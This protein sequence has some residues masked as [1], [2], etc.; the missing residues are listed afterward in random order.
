MLSNA[1][2]KK[3]KS[4]LRLANQEYKHLR[5]AYAI[6]LYKTYLLK[7]SKDTTALKQLASSYHKLNQYDSALKYWEKAV[8]LGTIKTAVLAELYANTSQYGQAKDLYKHIVNEN[9]TKVAEARLY[10]FTNINKLLADSLDYTLYNTKLNSGYNDFNGVL[11]KEGMVFESNRV[12]KKNKPKGL[13]KRLFTRT[14]QPSEFAWDG[15]GYSKLYFY[16]NLDSIRTSTIVNSNWKEKASQKNYIDYSVQTPND[17]KKIPGTYNTTIPSFDPNGVVNFDAFISDKMNVGAVSFTADGKRAYYTRNQ[18]RSNGIYQLEIWES[19]QFNGKWAVNNRMFFNNPSFS[20]FHPVITPDGK[21]LYYVSDD[22]TGYGGSDIYFIDKNPD[23]S[24]KNT[25]NLGQDINTAGN[26][27]FPT[28]YEGKL[29]I[30]SNGHPGLGGLDIYKI[31]LST[32]GDLNLKNAG[33]PINSAKD[34]FAFST[35]G[36]KGF[37]STNRYGSDDIIAFDF[38]QSFISMQGKIL[39][40]SNCIAGKKVYVYQK[41][42]KGNS[43]LKDSAVID[44]NCMYTFSARPNTE[45]ELVTFDNEEKR[46]SQN[47]VSDSYVKQNEHYIKDVALINIPL[48][49][50]EKQTKQLVK[51]AE[52]AKMTKKFKLTIDSLRSIAKDYVELHHP[53]DQVYIV[54]K[55][56]AD[57]YK[58][59]ELVKRTHNKKIV[60]VSAADCNGSIEYNEDLSQRRANRIYRTLTKLSNNEVVIKQV[61]ER[62]LLKACDDL[63]KS[64]E[65]NLVNRYSY[66]FIIDKN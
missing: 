1:Q 9:I 57:Y 59:I 42:E 55:D 24:W 50:K 30:S 4:L 5:Y 10:G 19:R 13:F 41:N 51:D 18:K 33:Y 26:E 17:T 44:N 25:V 23:G 43:I 45:Y 48:A 56:L 2:N 7:H 47:L 39:M 49:E 61:G 36:D 32:N 27:L 21:R 29:Y 38:H 20:Y 40:D 60:I 52:M 6:P 12:V 46:F 14:I 63:R 22:S 35:K 8:T 53:F 28:F 3:I 58:I 34:D 31:T 37:F 54:E 65:E 66:V 16:P 64:V 15:A 11:Y 62:E